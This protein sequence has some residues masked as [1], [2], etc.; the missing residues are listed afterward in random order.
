L[1]DTAVSWQRLILSST[2]PRFLSPSQLTATKDGLLAKPKLLFVDDENSIRVTLAEILRTEGFDVSVCATVPEA[3]EA[4]NKTKFNVLISDLNVGEPGDGFTVVSAMRRVQPQVI[5]FILTGYPDFESALK[6]IRNQVD[7]YIT[8][9][10]DVRSMVQSIR[11]HLDNPKP[12]HVPVPTKRVSQV[13]MENKKEVINAWYALVLKEKDLAAIKLSR[14]ERINHL[15]N[16]LD[17][18][19]NRIEKHPEQPDEEALKAS[20]DHGGTRFKHGYSIPQMVLEARLFQRV[21]SETLQAHLL[22]IDIS[23]L[24]PDMV[25]IGEALASQVEESIRAFQLNERRAA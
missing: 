3:I 1:A 25:A 10:A 5:T 8:K 20:A 18:L 4:I 23:T 16:L 24:I 21:I 19:C 7:D 9:P 11:K 13:L 15:P 12:V 17:G 2:T 6:A 14:T 22:V